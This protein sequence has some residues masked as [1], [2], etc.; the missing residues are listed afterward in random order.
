MIAAGRCLTT[1]H[2]EETMELFLRWLLTSSGEVC[3]YRAFAR[4]TSRVFYVNVIHINVAYTG[5]N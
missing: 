2:S 3:A 4:H 1:L 5:M